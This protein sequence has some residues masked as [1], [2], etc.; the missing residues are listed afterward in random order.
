MESIHSFWT[1]LA[2]L[3]WATPAFL[4]FMVVI[5]LTAGFFMTIKLRFIQI[6]QF[7]H[8]WK[9]LIG[10]YDDP[11][12]DG[13]ISHFQAISAALSATVGIGNIAGVATAIHYGG[14]GAL[15]WMWITAI[16]GMSLK[17]AEATLAIKFRKIT[18]EGEVAG[19]PMYY[20]E[21]GLGKKWKWMA[22]LFGV[23]LIISSLATGNTIQSFSV[24]DQFRS[25]YHIPTWLTGLVT[26]SII[27]LVIL[28]GIKRIGRVASI[29]APGMCLL[30]I[31]GGLTILGLNYETI[32]ST[33]ATIFTSAFTK[34]AKIGGFAGS[35]FLF[36]MVWGIKRGLFSN[37]AGQG[38]API[39]HAAAK[40]DKPVREGIVAMLGPFIDTLMV[41]TITGLV[42]VST[43][44][45]NEKDYVELPINA[46]SS[47]SII[48]NNGTIEQNSV[49][50]GEIITS[51]KLTVID[52][53]VENVQ[54][55]RNHSFVDDAIITVNGDYFSGELDV[56]K[57]GTIVH[58]HTELVLE[59]MMMKN[60]SPLTAW[61]FSKGLGK[62]GRFGGFLITISVFFF[63]ISTSISWSYYGD[64]GAYY[65]FGKKAIVAYK[66]LFVIASFLGSI[67]SLETVWAFGDV[68][69]G[70]MAIP[71]LVAI[72]LLSNLVKKDADK[73]T[74]T[75]QYTYKEELERQGK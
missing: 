34:S 32:P 58:D 57:N 41:C 33:F 12:D 1:S 49:I 62:Y 63:G 73:Y 70:L 4:P 21:K 3:M 10:K 13:D 75:K 5:L 20:I 59:G 52:G 51:K 45:W 18:P 56:D 30:Y 14:P 26:S 29:L 16:F 11:N 54:F 22:L 61:A 64:R 2:N 25:A 53:K 36:M 46:Q 47:I 7:L 50:N 27:G 69:I 35:S 23:M 60:G 39:A 66:W 43:G 65:L 37:E 6:R 17:F 67:V 55:V 68:A 15:F 48:D 19:G 40:T 31:I 9:V 38:S 8:G 71:N 42:I 24:A 28:G 72:L 74:S 44:V